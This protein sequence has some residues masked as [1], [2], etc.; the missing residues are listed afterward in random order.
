[1]FRLLL[2]IASAC[3]TAHP[4]ATRP[5]PHPA[6][7]LAV[8]DDLK[9]CRYYGALV[10]NDN[11][12]GTHTI[13]TVTVMATDYA[14]GTR[15][16]GWIWH[17]VQT[18]DARFQRVVRTNIMDDWSGWG[19]L[20]FPAD[21]QWLGVADNAYAYDA[22]ARNA[23]AR[24]VA[25]EPSPTLAS[26]VPSEAPMVP[27]GFVP[28]VTLRILGGGELRV[29]F[30]LHDVVFGDGATATRDLDDGRL[31][32][33]VKLAP[34][35]PRAPTAG[36]TTAAFKGTLSVHVEDDRGRAVDRSFAVTGP[37][38]LEGETVI[39]P[40]GFA[41]AHVTPKLC[42]ALDCSL[43]TVTLPAAEGRP[44]RSIHL[45][46]ISPFDVRFDGA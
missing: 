24:H 10:V 15:R 34:D 12:D 45:E 9:P 26:F 42:G 39:A 16:V 43:P 25:G 5:S 35:A 36:R 37:I 46:H 2:V 44:A 29:S 30:V 31:H 41:I 7:P 33:A 38:E 23:I 32:I 22:A 6:K 8:L 19:R 3:S 40:S 13:D 27:D 21:V 11:A 1:M 14:P 20:E 4:P 28:R 18:L 17:S